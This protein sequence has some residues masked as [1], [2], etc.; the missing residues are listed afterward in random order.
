MRWP[1]RRRRL[2]SL[3]TLTSSRDTDHSGPGLTL[4]RLPDDPAPVL[5]VSGE[6]DVYEA[7]AF[8]SE[9]F[10][11]IDEGHPRVVVDC[12]GMAFIDSAGL[13]ALVD[14]HRRVAANDGQL[15]LRGVRP[16]S[17]RIFEIT[18]LVTLFAFEGAVD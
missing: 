8:R 16:S 10:S 12:S 14:A 6:L 11:I 7:P 15:V 1:E 2:D 3:P 13:A 5:V 17:R 18:D 4:T 9:L